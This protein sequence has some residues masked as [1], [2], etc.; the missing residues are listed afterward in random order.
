MV[1][2]DFNGY[3]REPGLGVPSNVEAL[4][5]KAMQVKDKVQ[6]LQDVM[7]GAVD[8]GVTSGLLFDGYVEA[9]QVRPRYKNR[10]LDQSLQRIGQL[11]VAMYLQFYTVERTF[12]ITNVEGWPTYVKFFVQDS[13][14]G[15]TN[16]VINKSVPNA[17]G[18]Y[19]QPP[20]ETLKVKGIP[21]VQVVSG[22]SI[23]FQKAQQY[24]RA[25][26]LFQM[27]AIDQQA[28]LEDLDFPKKE[29]IL[30]RM[31]QAAQQQAQMQGAPSG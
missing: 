7:R 9:A 19:S 3:R 28:L 12:A 18:Q 21:D 2:N 4:F 26:E 17:E 23:P 10:N 30:Q 29:E 27:K 16:V 20:Q 11:D 8:P 22:S 15:T 5:D 24:N 14:D 25:K 6:G 13:P 1:L 31:Q